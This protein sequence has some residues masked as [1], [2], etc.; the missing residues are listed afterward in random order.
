MTILGYTPTKQ[1]IVNAILNKAQKERQIIHGARAVN[2]QLPPH[3]RR[4]TKDYDVYTKNPEKHAKELA[5][6]LNKKFKNGFKVVKGKHKGTF[7]V[8]K[9]DETIVDYTQVTKHPKT[10]NQLGV[11]YARTDYAKRKL[12]KLIR[13]ETKAFRREKDIETLEKLKRGEL[14]WS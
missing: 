5:N 13:D 3:L 9:N 11:R 4:K 1:D 6:E 14:R 2:I 10:I 8:K 12:R 7:K